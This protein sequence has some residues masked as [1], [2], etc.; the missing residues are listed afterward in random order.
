MAWKLGQQETNGN[1]GE[2]THE[3]DTIELSN[4]QVEQM[5]YIHFIKRLLHMLRDLADGY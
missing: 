2:H 5:S 4:L 1:E 3:M